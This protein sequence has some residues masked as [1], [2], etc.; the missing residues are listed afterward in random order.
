MDPTGELESELARSRESAGRLLENLA[1]RVGAIP[2]V[3]SAAQYWQEHTA[4]D[5]AGEMNRVMQR[6]PLPAIAAALLAGFL[7][8]RA[9]E[10]RRRTRFL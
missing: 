7:L 3:R 5:M 8:G 10:G 2:A 1:Q 6:N 9:V 4:R